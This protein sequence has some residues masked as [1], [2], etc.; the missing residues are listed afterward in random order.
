MKF[1]IQIAIESEKGEPERVHEVARLERGTLRAEELGLTLTEAKSILGEIQQAMVERQVV[2]F[3]AERDECLHCSRKLRRKGKHEIVFRTAFGKLKLE[4]PRFYPCRC[5]TTSGKSFSPLAELLQERT[6]PELLYLETKWAALMSYGLTVDLLKDVLPISQDISTTA[7]RHEVDHVVQRMEDKLGEEKVMYV[8]G[9]PRDWEKLP[10]PNGTFTVGIDGG[11][12][13][14]RDQKSRQS[15]WFEVI[16]GKSIPTTGEAKCFGFVHRYDQKPKRRLYEMLKSQGMQMNQ[17]VTFLSDGGETVRDLQRYLTPQAEHLLDWF[18]IT[19]RL[20]VMGQIAKG[21]ASEDGPLMDETE[22]RLDTTKIQKNLERLKWNLWHGNV[23]R[24]LQLVDDLAS[25]LET[26]EESSE[27]G[28]KLLKAVRE[29]GSYIVANKPFIPN[30]GDR[31]RHG[32]IISTGFV[33]STVNQVV[34]KRFAKK[35][36]MRWT[37]KG[38]HQLLQIRT[39]VLNEEWHQTLRG[40]YPAMQASPDVAA[41]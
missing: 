16:V 6:S 27:N 37:E 36:Q 39:K 23:Y 15:G 1:R 14:S 41:A 35:Q 12:V 3:V 28:K 29:F 5:H 2:D 33:E 22:D 24:A 20:T 7:I 30:Y 25:D 13:H 38:A 4:S 8:E 9:C 32:E 31:Y 19:M 17:Q 18:H 21:L 40:W 34:S 11:Y 26:I 10:D